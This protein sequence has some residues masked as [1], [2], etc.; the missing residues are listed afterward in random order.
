MLGWSYSH[1]MDGSNSIGV[2]MKLTSHISLLAILTIVFLA[3][4]NSATTAQRFLH[5]Q[6]KVD[7]KLAFE[8]K[9]GVPEE[10]AVKNM[11]DTIDQATFETSKEYAEILSTQKSKSETHKLAGD[12]VIQIS[13]VGKTLATS[14]VEALQMKKNADGEWAIVPS[15]LDLLKQSAVEK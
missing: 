3:G 9:S 1:D 8:T 12:V 11:W 13:H 4:C 7:D 15:E 14:T 6:I 10:M 2:T 5:F